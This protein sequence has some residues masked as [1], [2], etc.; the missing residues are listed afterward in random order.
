MKQILALSLMLTAS[1]VHA[2]QY[3]R[4]VGGP[5]YQKQILNE[6]C[7]NPRLGARATTNC[8]SVPVVTHSWR[9][10]FVVLPN[11]DWALLT[12]GGA[13]GHGPAL[14]TLGPAANLTPALKSSLLSGLN[15]V[16]PDS[17]DNLKSLLQPA[18]LSKGPDVTIN[19][20]AKWG[21]FPTTNAAIR[22]SFLL[23]SV[24]PALS[25]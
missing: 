16:A 17:F 8:T 1:H 9:D 4:Y 25:F 14:L 15:L 12:V 23:L 3:F 24:G 20:G 2:S 21:I 18:P 11:E 22:T 7:F 5:G 13:F 10:G 6:A 19:I